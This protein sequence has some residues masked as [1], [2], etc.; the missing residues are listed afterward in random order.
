MAKR[1]AASLDI[2]LTKVGPSGR[3]QAEV[4]VAPSTPVD[5]IA[6]LVRKHVTRNT[7]LL[8]KVGLRACGACLSGLDIWI[9]HRFDEVIRVDLKQMG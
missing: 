1:Q 9:R 8:R 5:Q 2:S 3:P 6:G 4:L 7:D